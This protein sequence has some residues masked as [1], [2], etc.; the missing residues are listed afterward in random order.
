MTYPTQTPTVDL[1]LL[2]F[3]SFPVDDGLAHAVTTRHGGVS[4]PPWATLN[5]GG[6]VH[7]DPAAVYENTERMCAALDVP[8]ASLV[9][10]YMVAGNRVAVAREEHRGQFFRETDAL[11]TTTPGVFLTL[12]Y[13]DCVPALLVDPVRRAVGIA[14]AGWRG[15]LALVTQRTAEAMM[16]EFGCRAED[17][18]AA[19]GPS[20][21]P[22]CYEVGHEVVAQARAV[23]G[24]QADALLLPRTTRTH[25]DLWQ[26]NRLQLEAVGVGQVEVA[27]ICTRCH[28][29]DYFSHR[30]EGGRTGRFGAVIGYR[31]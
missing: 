12:R 5:L 31:A 4:Q 28:T 3:A 11:V 10:A 1:P 23:F 9:T 19:I 14:H 16:A 29:H 20:I 22:C 2:R 17:I 8:R 6:S 13:A 21:G 15:T 24:G 7:D 30:G 27:G 18:R 25:L 26:A